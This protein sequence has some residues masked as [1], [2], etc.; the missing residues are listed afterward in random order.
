MNDRGVWLGNGTNTTNTSG[1]VLL[2][3][4]ANAGGGITLKGSSSKT[5]GDTPGIELGDLLRIVELSILSN[6]GPIL[7]VSKLNT[8]N[9]TIKINANNLELASRTTMTDVQG[10]S[11]LLDPHQSSQVFR[12]TKISFGSNVLGAGTVEL[13]PFTSGRAMS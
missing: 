13:H 3:S 5:T 1:T 2:Q 8:A 9:S 10:V 4:T 11:P 6:A 7:L 12:Q